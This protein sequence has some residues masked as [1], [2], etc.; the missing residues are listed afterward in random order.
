MGNGVYISNYTN[1][2]MYIW[3]WK[4]KLLLKNI[5]K[6]NKWYF[7]EL[8][9]FCNLKIIIFTSLHLLFNNKQP[10]EV[11][12]VTIW[13]NGTVKFIFP[14]HWMSSWCMDSIRL[15][16]SAEYFPALCCILLET[17]L[18]HYLD[19]LPYQPQK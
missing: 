14:V 7:L 15:V 8:R 10:L 2:H 9:S 1:I 19:F 4:K 12:G 18:F 5:Q 17:G 6:Y 3:S 13:L 16:L 11:G